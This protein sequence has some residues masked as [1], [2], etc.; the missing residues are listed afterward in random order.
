VLARLAPW[1]YRKIYGAFTGQEVL[2]DGEEIV[3]R[4]GARYCALLEGPPP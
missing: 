2:A 3:A 1:R 4:S